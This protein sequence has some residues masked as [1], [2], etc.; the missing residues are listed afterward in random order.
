MKW[1]QANDVRWM[2]CS[3]QLELKNGKIFLRLPNAP[4]KSPSTNSWAIHS[5]Q[6]TPSREN[7]TEFFCLHFFALSL[8]LNPF[9]ARIHQSNGKCF[10]VMNE[11]LFILNLLHRH[12][13][14]DYIK[15]FGKFPSRT[16]C[17]HIALVLST[18]LVFAIS[19]EKL[20][21]RNND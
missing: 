18:F 15:P 17:L 19:L 8:I 5:P 1:L 6:I 20:S 13:T 4:V 16:L 11:C 2:E 9:Q 7:W 10:N 12:I 3:T 14:T 21:V